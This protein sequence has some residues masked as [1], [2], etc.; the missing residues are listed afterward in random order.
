[1]NKR[2]TVLATFFVSFALILIGRLYYLQV[3]KG[4][5]YRKL[6]E[7]NFL[8]IETINPSRGKIYDRNGVLLA[9]DVPYYELY[10]VPAMIKKDEL[11]LLKANLEKFLGIKVDDKKLE[12]IKNK[13]YRKIVIKG[14]LSDEDLKKY[15]NYANLLRGVFIDVVPRRKYT[16]FANYMPHVLGYVGYPSKKELEDNPS[17]KSDMLI[18]KTGVEKIYNDLLRGEYGERA[19]I[20]DAKGR[21]KKVLWEKPPKEGKD[22]YLTIDVRHQKIAYEAFKNSGQKSGAVFIVNPQTY[23]IYSI[24]SYPTFNLQKFSDGLSAKEWKKLI[25]NKY[26]PL[27][28]KAL[29]GLYPPGSIY[30]IIVST[31]ALEEGVI[32]PYTKIYSGWAYRIGKW[33]YRN[34]NPAGCGKINVVQALEQSCDTF[35]YQVGIKLGVDRI[36]DYTYL[37]GIGE[38]LNPKIETKVSRVPTPD[39]KLRILGEPWFYGDTVNLSIGQGFLAITPFDSV[40]IVVPVVNGGKLLKPRLLKAYYDKDKK[41]FIETKT[42]VIKNLGISSLTR[43]TVKKG[44]YMVVYGKRGT[45]KIMRKAPVKNAGK[46]G[47]AQVYRK[48]S[49]KKK[50]EEKWELKNHAWFVDFF[51]YKHPKFV[52]STFVEHGGGGSKAAAPITKEIIEKLY[53]KGL[54]SGG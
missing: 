2:F 33:I 37:F 16:E 15:Y 48:K 31:A 35:F 51:P 6:A 34:W 26:K 45:A 42:E 52:I 4:D 28:N 27:F 17:L 9:Y 20:T 23:E 41:E 25:R 49:F 39:W 40:K 29:N 19:V 30:K 21:I 24:L 8:R 36:V 12:L 46:T 38:K 5:Y 13:K 54:I 1:M 18:G 11:P 32:T 43:S 50:K 10:V 3:E 44:M 53:E 14:K 22:I 7:Q 47:T